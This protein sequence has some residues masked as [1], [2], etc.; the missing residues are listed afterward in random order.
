[1]SQVRRPTREMLSP[2]GAGMKILIADDVIENRYLLEFTLRS[3]GHEVVSAQDGEEALAA[4]GR[5]RFDLVISDILMPRM[6]GFQLC[7]ELKRQLTVRDVPFVFYTATYT[8][9]KDVE[10]GLSL[11]AARYLVKPM[12]PQELLGVLGA[13][14]AQAAS[15]EPG[16]AT[17]ADLPEETFLATYT[18]RLVRKLDGKV[19]ELR[20]ALASKEREEAER[21]L[22]E[23]ALRASEA[24][25]SAAQRIAGVG[26]WEVRVLDAERLPRSELRCTAEML[27][28][29]GRSGPLSTTLTA[30]DLATLMAVEDRPRLEAAMHKVLAGGLPERQEFLLV[31]PDGIQRPIQLNIEARVPSWGG[32]RVLTGTAQDLTERKQLEECAR[33][34][35]KME[36][37]GLLAAGIAHDF[38]NMLSAMLLNA[39]S[40][41]DGGA[42]SASDAEAVR[43]IAEAGERA[44]QLTQQVLTFARRRPALLQRVDLREVIGGLTSMLCRIIGER[45]TLKCRLAAEP[46]PA[47]SDAGLLGQV[48]MNLVVNARDAMPAGGEVI[49]DAD[50]VEIDVARA[51]RVPGARPGRAIRITVSDTGAGI[52]PEN[53]PRLFEPFFT[54]KPSGKGTGLGLATVHGIVALHRGWIEVESQVGK[55]SR[56]LVFLPL[57]EAELEDPACTS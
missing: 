26:S 33:Q 39:Q 54:T 2:M 20:E 24:A 22:A 52:P 40:V 28:I 4:T 50:R 32:E 18:Q 5:D 51:A 27:R 29:L 11:G 19:A 9:E 48:L 55:G 42:L 8:D 31:L 44:M 30:A 56:F 37:L 16:S 57:N 3:A 53:V 7:R 38:R 12:D 14:M 43:E 17:A 10:F 15:S 25:L 13:V 23:D 1:M 41:L 47:L 35:Q 45:V 46:L 34:A 21:R 49:I 6:D 36:N